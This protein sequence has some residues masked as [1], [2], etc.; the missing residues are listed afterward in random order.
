MYKKFGAKKPGEKG[1]L[2]TST[3]S[4]AFNFTYCLDVCKNHQMVTYWQSG[5]HIFHASTDNIVIAAVAKVAAY[6]RPVIV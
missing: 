2:L 3:A 4:V 6:R 1:P 5:L